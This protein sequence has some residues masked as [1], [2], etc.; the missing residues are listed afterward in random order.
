[1]TRNEAET[2]AEL[3]DPVLATAGW[4][5]VDGSRVGINISNIHGPRVVRVFLALLQFD[6]VCEIGIV[7]WVGFAHVAADVEL[8]VPDLLGWCAFVKEQHDGTHTST[9]ERSSWEIQDGV[10][11]AG[12]K[13]VSA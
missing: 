12:F 3:I 10:Q 11:V 9:L 6:K 2:R 8:V 4:G 5:Q 13:K 7:K 1:M